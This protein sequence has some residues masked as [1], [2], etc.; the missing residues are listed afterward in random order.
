M[1]MGWVGLDFLLQFFRLHCCVC[2][3]VE[4]SGGT[5][6]YLMVPRCLLLPLINP[7]LYL[8]W[9]VFCV[10]CVLCVLWCDPVL[11]PNGK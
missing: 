11:F 9:Y 2:V 6:G 1:V 3:A 8:Y 4:P 5:L 7:F 10:S